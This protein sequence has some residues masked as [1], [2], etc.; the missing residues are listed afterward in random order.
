MARRG[1]SRPK[2]APKRIPVR[3]AVD[4]S[5]LCL[6]CGLCCD[7]TLFPQ[8]PLDE[9]EQDFAESLGLVVKA[10]PGGGIALQMPCS[11]FIDGCCSLY[12]VG[13]PAVC[14]SYRCALLNGYVAGT[15]NLDEVLPIVHLV[16]SLARELEV[17]MGIPTGEYTRSAL[18]QYLAEQTP[19][20]IGLGA[21]TVPQ[22]LERFL[23]ALS[24][25]N[26]LGEKYFDY[27][28]VTVEVQASAVGEQVAAGG[29]Y[30][31]G[32]TTQ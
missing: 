24:R 7:G 25:L 10:K 12:T 19:W 26:L 4:G 13:R 16:R 2:R 17:E 6:Q 1:K 28:P 29:V 9:D 21:P 31:R 3:A 30:E 15:K 14:G 8:A 27:G 23:V 5:D 20:M 22:E 18:Q 11:R 32:K